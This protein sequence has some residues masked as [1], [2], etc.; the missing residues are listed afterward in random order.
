VTISFLDD[1]ALK[2]VPSIDW[3]A[4]LRTAADRFDSQP[5]VTDGEGSCLSYREL[6]DGAH[7][8]ARHLV[9]VHGLGVDRPVATL[10]PNTTAGVMA[11]YAIRMAGAIEVPI[12]WGSTPEELAWC[13]KL[14]HVSLVLSLAS[15]QEGLH[16]LGLQAICVDES[17]AATDPAD[18]VVNAADVNRG[19]TPVPG[20]APGRILFT[21]GT[22][23]KPKGVLYRHIDRWTGEQML[24]ASLPFVPAVG[25]KILL[26]TPFVHGAS[27]M[28]YAWCDLGGHVVLL[29]GVILEKIGEQLADPRL[30]AIFAPPT[31]LAKITSAFEGQTFKQVDCVFTGTQPLTA[32][33][34]ERACAMF[35]PVVRVTYGKSECVNPITVLSTD[36]THA[37]FSR[38]AI[39]AGACVGHPAPG[40]QIRIEPQD[41]SD[42]DGE[43]G[44]GREGYGEVWLKAPHMSRGMIT[45]DG[46]SAHEPSGWHQT[47]DLGYMDDGGRLV[48]TGR[49][50]DVIKTGGFKVN[51]DEIEATLVAL[52]ASIQISVTAL[53]SDYWGEIIVAVAESSFDG[54]ASAAQA[55]LG[56]LSRH[57][58]PRLFVAVQALPRNPQ[59]KVSRR[60]VREQVL[61]QYE[62]LDGPYPEIK[63]RQQPL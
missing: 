15:R 24:K 41:D 39:P 34:Y 60:L 3:S 12:S 35:G 14:A 59:G 52:D 61:A 50:A 19:F 56:S 2:A 54:W 48:L 57:K 38:S 25:D 23:G 20:E 7:R 51:P 42:S 6:C 44:G 33:M 62:L 49:M 1:S 4:S 58:H 28:T 18:A 13:A 9:A 17:S 40:V 36:Q 27:L 63:R 5:A 16:A 8:L 26:M 29:D 10:L 37:Y 47:G 31:V 55:R 21:S 43:E 53:P 46:F 22:T 45:L 32:L 30:R 11:S